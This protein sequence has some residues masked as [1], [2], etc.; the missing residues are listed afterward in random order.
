[1]FLFFLFLWTMVSSSIVAGVPGPQYQKPTAKFALWEL[2]ASSH[3]GTSSFKY[4]GPNDKLV[5]VADCNKLLLDLWKDYHFTYELFNWENSTALADHFFVLA[6]NGDCE[7]ALK[8]LDGLDN[9]MLLGDQDIKEVVN[10]SIANSRDGVSFGTV[11][12]QMNC[13]TDSP[14]SGEVNFEWT[15]RTPG[16]INWSG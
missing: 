3:C 10:S 8:R 6:T 13:D 2:T 16:S 14:N 12:G 1:M 9:I 7:F 5:P 11:E 15:L 4:F